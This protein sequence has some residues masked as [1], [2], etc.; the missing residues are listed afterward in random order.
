LGLV[1]LALFII[2]KIAT[3]FI[4]RIATDRRY[5]GRAILS[6]RPAHVAFSVIAGSA[7]IA[8]SITALDPE[9]I[10]ESVVYT[11][12]PAVAAAIQL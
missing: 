4:L 12:L 5:T 9:G 6:K 1:L 7:T 10:L 8:R 2:S 11:V 3:V